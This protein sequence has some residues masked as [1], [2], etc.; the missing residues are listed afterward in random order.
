M[1]DYERGFEEARRQCL[2]FAEERMKSN[3]VI[4]DALPAID[5]AAGTNM[6]TSL[7]RRCIPMWPAVVREPT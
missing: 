4:A 3:S 2:A 5:D 1:T 7:S 6:A